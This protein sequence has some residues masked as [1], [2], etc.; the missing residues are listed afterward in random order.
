[1]PN[2]LIRDL[3]PE[4]HAH[5]QQRASALGQSLQQYLTSELTRMAQTPSL[6]EVIERM[7]Q[8][9]KGRVGFQQAV[10]D[11]GAAR[12]DREQPVASDGSTPT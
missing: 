10:E 11:L 12:T 6:S 2:V 1:M 3:P 5:L 8:R 4:V 7:E 9:A